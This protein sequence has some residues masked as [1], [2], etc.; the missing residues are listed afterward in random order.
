[1]I[2]A[3]VSREHWT[4]DYVAAMPFDQLLSWAS[5]GSGG[6]ISEEDVRERRRKASENEGE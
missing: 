4:V 3:V 1:M 5:C 6:E 2:R